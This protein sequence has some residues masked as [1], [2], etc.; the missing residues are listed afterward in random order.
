[1]QPIIGLTTKQGDSEWIEGHSQ[2][3]LDRLNEF[4]AK[5]VILSPDYPAILP[6]GTAFEPDSMGRLPSRVLNHLDGLILAGGGDVHPKYFGA[7]M[8]GANPKAISQMR[9][10]LELSLAKEAL[11][12]DMPIFGICRGCQ[13]LNVAG[14]GGMVQHFDGHRSSKAKPIF[15]DILVE[16]NS[17]FYDLVGKERFPTNT[18]HHQGLDHETLA[19]IFDAVG[20]AEPDKWLVEAIESPQHHWVFGVQWHPEKLYELEDTHRKLW[21]DFVETCRMREKWVA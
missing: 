1:M 13:V 5:P 21:T 11:A 9:D 7:E 2:N 18:Y 20:V 17:R 10:E 4:G 19:P 14:G 16:P 12:R 8:N 15:H 6:D 3:Y